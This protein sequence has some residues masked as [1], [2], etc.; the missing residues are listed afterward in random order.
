MSEQKEDKTPG[1]DP[2]RLD[3]FTWGDDDIVW[4]NPKVQKEWQALT[5]GQTPAEKKPKA[6]RKLLTK[7]KVNPDKPIVE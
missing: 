7:K 1:I 6:P 4:V 2:K 5:S 3:K